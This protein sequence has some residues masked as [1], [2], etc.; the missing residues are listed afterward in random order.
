MGKVGACLLSVE[1]V[2]H[3]VKKSR[4]AHPHEKSEKVLEFESGFGKVRE[5]MFLPEV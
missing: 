4:S 5:N 3:Y 2:C 1:Q